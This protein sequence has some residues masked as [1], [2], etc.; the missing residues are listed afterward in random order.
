MFYLSAVSLFL[1]FYVGLNEGNL[2]VVAFAPNCRINRRLYV[3]TSDY[4]SYV[5]KREI[6]VVP[7]IGCVGDSVNEAEDN[8]KK[9]L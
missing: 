3:C 1:T 5:N 4:L 2:Q 6:N 9:I 7:Q 8:E